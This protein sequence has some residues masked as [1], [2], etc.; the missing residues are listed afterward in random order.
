[1]MLLRFGRPWELAA[2]QDRDPAATSMYFLSGVE[3]LLRDLRGFAQRTQA[4]SDRN[5]KWNVILGPCTTQKSGSTEV[6]QKL[7]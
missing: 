3:S 4:D 6:V 1:M 7:L 5:S 2:S